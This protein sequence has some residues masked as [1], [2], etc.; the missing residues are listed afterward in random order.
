VDTNT[1]HRYIIWYE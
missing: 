1:T